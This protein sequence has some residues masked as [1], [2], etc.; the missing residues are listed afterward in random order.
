VE[1]F[2]AALKGAG[3]E[4]AV[5]E[6]GDGEDELEGGTVVPAEEGGVAVFGTDVGMDPKAVGSGDAGQD[7]GAETIAEGI[8]RGEGLTGRVVD[9]GVEGRDTGEDGEDFT[10]GWGRDGRDSAAGD[11]DGFGLGPVAGFFPV[12]LENGE[13]ELTVASGGRDV[14]GVM[15]FAGGGERF[16]G[17]GRRWGDGGAK[18]FVPAGVAVREGGWRKGEAGREGFAE[19]GSRGAGFTLKEPAV[20]GF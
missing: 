12:A 20:I 11:A 5:T 17:V 10:V 9:V 15:D 8:G 1:A 2:V 19:L 18:E 16:W 6:G 4:E 14:E 7:D 13:D 3:Q